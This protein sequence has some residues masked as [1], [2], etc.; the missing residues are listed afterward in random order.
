MMIKIDELQRL[1]RTI[2]C[3][4]CGSVLKYTWLS[5]LNNLIGVYSSDGNSVLVSEK[6][7]KALEKMFFPND[8]E[9]YEF[10]Q[11]FIIT[12]FPD[13]KFNIASNAQ[14]TNCHYEFPYSYAD[15]LQARLKDTHVILMD[16]V[17]LVEDNKIS[18]VHVYLE[19]VM[20]DKKTPKD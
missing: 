2:I 7:K 9:R 16:G 11:K 13:G 14:C 4:V 8:D 5:G 1:G 19:P 15:N 12:N 3:P 17:K 20:Q 18:I 10:I 6:F